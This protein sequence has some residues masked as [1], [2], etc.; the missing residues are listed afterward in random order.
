MRKKYLKIYLFQKDFLRIW[1]SCITKFHEVEIYWSGRRSFLQRAES[2]RI[3]GMT[4]VLANAGVCA[5]ART[6]VA[7]LIL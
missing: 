7:F 3:L 1:R 6:A 5:I 4:V 2:Y